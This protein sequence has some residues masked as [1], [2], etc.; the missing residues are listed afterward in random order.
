MTTRAAAL[1]ALLI[2][3][4]AQGGCSQAAKTGAAA[5]GKFAGLD[6]EILTWR[7]EIIAADPLCKSQAEGQKCD[8]FDVACKA[9]RTVTPEDQARGITARVVAAMTWNGFDTKFLHAQNGSRTAEFVK[10]AS[11]W[12]RAEHKPVNMGSCA[13]L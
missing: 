12:T 13:D 10:N 3:A 9:E 6:G 4:C 8:S 7:K 1:A 2:L 11:G 5:T